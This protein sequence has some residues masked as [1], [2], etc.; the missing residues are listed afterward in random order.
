MGV[1]CLGFEPLPMS[2]RCRTLFPFGT[3]VLIQSR[4]WDDAK[5]IPALLKRDGLDMLR[6]EQGQ[7]VK[8][9][10]CQCDMQVFRWLG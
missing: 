4:D 1:G 5:S 9:P 10:N 8:I 7:L 6:N 2:G 3:Y